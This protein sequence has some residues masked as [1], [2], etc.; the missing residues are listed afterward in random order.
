MTIN[1][2][3]T[4]GL[5]FFKDSKKLYK[6]AIKLENKYRKITDLQTKRIL[7]ETIEKIKSAGEQFIKLETR[8]R[9]DKY[10]VRQEY[11]ELRRQYEEIFSYIKKENIKKVLISVGVFGAI[12]AGIAVSIDKLDKFLID[13]NVVISHEAGNFISTNPTIVGS[14]KM[15][16]RICKE[17]N[18]SFK[19]ISSIIQKESEWNSN[20]INHNKN[21]TTD[22]GLMQLNSGNKNMFEKYFWD[23]KTKFDMKKPEDNVYVGIKYFKSLLKQY[24]N[25]VKKALTAYNAGNFA[26]ATN[27]IPE[28]TI[29]YRNDIL[30]NF[31][32]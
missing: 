13:N 11:K 29:H 9:N 3:L 7:K 24:D 28:T 19:L 4:E 22:Y 16:A 26:V 25:D 27:K 14:K 12:T 15:V 31:H 2:L 30:K 21:G 17:Q 5:V 20:N 32:S 18:I 6:L 23:K 1:D 8:Y 10:I